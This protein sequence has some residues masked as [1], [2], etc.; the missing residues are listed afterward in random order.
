MHGALNAHGGFHPQHHRNELPM[1]PGSLW[2][3]IIHR[4]GLWAVFKLTDNLPCG[5]FKCFASKTAKRHTEG[6]YKRA[7]VVVILLASQKASD[8]ARMTCLYARAVS[9]SFVQLVD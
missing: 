3:I 5:N 4:A 6:P 9:F 7:Q 1:A 2:L 8:S